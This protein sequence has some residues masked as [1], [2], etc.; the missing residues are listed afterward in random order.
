MHRVVSGITVSRGNTAPPVD[1][2]KIRTTADSIPVV[3][4][5]AMFQQLTKDR[6]IALRVSD[7]SQ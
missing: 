5:M 6:A 4:V 1:S 7:E 2:G 3:G